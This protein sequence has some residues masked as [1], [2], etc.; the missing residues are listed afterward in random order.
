VLPAAAWGEKE[1]TFINSERRFGLLKKVSRAPGQALSDFNIVTLAAHY[2]GCGDMFKEWTSPEAVFQILKRLSIGQPCDFNG[3][4]DYQMIDQAG[5]IQWPCPEGATPIATER[6]LFEDGVFYTPDGKAKFVSGI[7]RAMPESVDA[8]Y[9]LLLLT[10]RGTSAQ[11]HTQSRTRKSAVL[12]Q[13]YPENIYVE[14]NPVDATRHN[15][16]PNSWVE[17]L[18]RRGSLRAQAHVTGNVG[19]GQIFIPM[20]YH[21]TNRLTHPSFDPQ[22]RQPSYK[23]CAVALRAISRGIH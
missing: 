8:D 23:A 22:S 7:P 5:G 11:W 13:L 12:R 9:P 1:G 3:I 15:I 2:W 16:R 4:R 10:G 19:A 21:E 20:H 6:R 14:I 17:V 18:S